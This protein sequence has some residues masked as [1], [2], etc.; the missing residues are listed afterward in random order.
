[1]VH[2]ESLTWEVNSLYLGWGSPEIRHLC[3]SRDGLSWSSPA[4]ADEIRLLL[5]LLGAVDDLPELQTFKCV[6]VAVTG[7][8]IVLCLGAAVVEGRY[9]LTQPSQLPGS[10]AKLEARP[11]LVILQVRAGGHSLLPVAG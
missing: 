2:H 1:M 8:N 10:P 3:V 5:A 4:H 6:D 11:G 7:A 9:V